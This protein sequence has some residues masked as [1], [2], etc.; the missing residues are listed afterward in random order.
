MNNDQFKPTNNLFLACKAQYILWQLTV[1]TLVF[2]KKSIEVLKCVTQLSTC[3]KC[4]NPES[5][6]TKY[7]TRVNLI[8]TP[9]FQNKN[10][11]TTTLTLIKDF[12]MSSTTDFALLCLENPLLGN[13]LPQLLVNGQA[14][15]PYSHR[16]LLSVKY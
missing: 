15:A 10:Y 14:F 3:M 5:P 16:R 6:T 4:C 1:R 2:K 13:L 12:I 11:S 8:N 9:P 7:C